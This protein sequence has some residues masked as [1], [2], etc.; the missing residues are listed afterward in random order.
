MKRGW[1]QSEESNARRAAAHFKHGE[2]PSRNGK[3]G[4]IEYCARLSM[5]ARCA[6]YDKRNRKWYTSRGIT[7]CSRWLGPKG[8]AHF[9]ADMGRKPSPKLTLDRI[10]NDKGYNPRNCRWATRSQQMLN[11][12]RW[13]K[14]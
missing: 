9:L 14:S 6:G 1:T 13:R 5:K 2:A 8:F 4:T 12:R 11:S 3:K 10:N 7:V